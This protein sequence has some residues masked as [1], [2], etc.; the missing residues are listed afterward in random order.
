MPHVTD[1]LWSPPDFWIL[2]AMPLMAAVLGGLSNYLPWRLLFGSL[3]VNGSYH[4][5]ILSAHATAVAG[6][7]GDAL[8][9]L[10]GLSELFRLM[11]PEKIAAH[12][13]AA[14]LER[15]DDYVDAVMSEK[16]GVLWDNLPVMVRRRVYARVRRQ[17]PS[18]LDN[19][20]DDLAENIEQLIDIQSLVLELLERERPLLVRLFQESLQA[21]G[22]FLLH[23]GVLT[24][25]LLGIA[26]LLLW[27]YMPDPRL[28]PLF[29][30]A[31]ALASQWLPRQFLFWPVTPVR[32]GA[33]VFQGRILRHQIRLS[34]SIAFRLGEDVLSLRGLMYALLSG[35][36]AGR[37]RAMIKR[38]MRPLMEAG[39]VR[40]SLQLLM[41][42]ESYAHI[43][44]RVVDRAVILT[45]EAL[46]DAD[47][48]HQCSRQIQG[49]CTA[50]LEAA[51]PP[52]LTWLLRSVLEEA[53]WLQ[54][55]VITTVGALFGLMQWLALAVL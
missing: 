27:G 44:Q 36:R 11:E 16:N 28:L 52:G 38:H 21:E 43:K 22:R 55:L 35:S 26:E 13:S 54:W 12:V 51:D 48:N 47:F 30:S 19:F 34:R 15:L 3:P 4:Q 49:L 39:M 18:I 6:R 10:V 7:L 8:L 14:V 20:V 45:M 46:S 29:A 25:L 33:L 32:L 31:I 2:L 40:T 42:A 37:T 23:A 50:R 41:G 53:M 1:A 5:G 9:P 24:G 17:L